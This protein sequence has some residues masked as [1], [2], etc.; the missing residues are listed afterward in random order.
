MSIGLRVAWRIIYF[1]VSS[2]FL[3][4]SSTCVITYGTYEQVCGALDDIC[5]FVY[6]SQEVH[7]T[8]H[9]LGAFVWKLHLVLRGALRFFIML[10]QKLF[11]GTSRLLIFCWTRFVNIILKGHF[12]SL[13]C[14]VALKHGLCQVFHIFRYLVF[15][16]Q[17]YDLHWQD[18]NAKLSDFGLARD[19]P[20]GD[21]SHVSTRVMGTYGY[22]APEYLSTG[23]SP[24]YPIPFSSSQS[25]G[26][27]TQLSPQTMNFICTFSYTHLLLFIVSG[28]RVRM[29]IREY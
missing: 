7:T 1:G 2:T 4:Y 23:L 22:A 17:V 6:L 29:I 13:H 8:N 24:C 15:C 18:Y 10:K 11:T 28:H 5:G 20:V 16:T 27:L 9:F 3:L 25:D 21:Q 12:Y 26:I 19:G 14:P